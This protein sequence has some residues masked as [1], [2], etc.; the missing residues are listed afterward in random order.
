MCGKKIKAQWEW[1]VDVSTLIMCIP[2]NYLCRHCKKEGRE[3]GVIGR[4]SACV[5]LTHLTKIPKKASSYSMQ[6]PAAVCA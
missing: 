3:S 2:K 4:V 5:L 6:Y 1:V